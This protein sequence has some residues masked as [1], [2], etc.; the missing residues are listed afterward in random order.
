M[1][2]PPVTGRVLV[3]A[4]VGTVL[5]AGVPGSGVAA[6]PTGEQ[7]VVPQQVGV[8]VDE[9]EGTVAIGGR[10]TGDPTAPRGDV[11][12]AGQFLGTATV[13]LGRTNLVA[14]LTANASVVSDVDDVLGTATAQG[15]VDASVSWLNQT[16]SL[17]RNATLPSLQPVAP[18]AMA[19]TGVLPGSAG[20]QQ[21]GQLSSASAV[22][23]PMQTTGANPFTVTFWDF[24]GFMV[25]LLLGLVLVGI[26]PRFSNR[27]AA[28]AASDVLQTGAIGL[29]VLVAAPLVLLLFALS[30]FG[31]PIALVGGLVYFVVAWAGAI[32]GR[33]A[34]GVWLLAVVPR[35]LSLVG[36][37][38][39]PIENR[40]AA[41]LVGL[42]V[43]GLAIQIPYLGPV[44]DVVVIAVGLGAIT[45]MWLQTYRRTERSTATGE[46]SPVATDDA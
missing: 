8:T 27:V 1:R 24:Y 15:R 10:V 14:T 7:P 2:L 9:F 3:L 20:V 12:A 13:A 6:A 32:Y 18:M 30:L 37:E 22:L 31:L 5:L 19:A 26:F 36:V 46:A 23:V 4:V 11:G 28:G 39:E 33:F 42:L 40:W 21:V 44:V 38:R 41:L 16:Y 25:N 43:V 45:K 34:V 29:A 17:E 35:Q